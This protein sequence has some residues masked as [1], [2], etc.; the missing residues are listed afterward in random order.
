MTQ[1][2]LTGTSL[3]ESEAALT[4]CRELDESR[5]HLFSTAGVHPHD[6]SQWTGDSASQLRALLAEPEVRAVG[7]CGLTSTATR[8]DRNRNAPWKSSCNSQWKAQCRCSS[9]NGTPA[10]DWWRS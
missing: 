3:A 9:T 8:P 2:V 1:M 10:N 5:Q 7:E 4:L 6:A